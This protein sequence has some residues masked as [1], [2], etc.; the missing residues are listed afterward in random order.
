ML[1]AGAVTLTR[2]STIPAQSLG[3]ASGMTIITGNDGTGPGVNGGTLIFA[4]LTPPVT[5][6]KAAVAINYNPVSYA[7]PTDYAGKFT[8]TEGATL[9]QRMLVFPT[10][11]K[12]ADGSTSVV[13]TG[14]NGLP[15]GVTLV[16]G[17]GATA[18]FDTAGA[19]TNIGITYSGYTLAGPD[20]GKYALAVSCC[21]LPTRSTGTI[22]AAPVVVV[23]PVV[24][25]PVVVP[26]VVVP[27]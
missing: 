17:P 9:T 4:P 2:G 13:L 7:A 19:G 8:L 20:A 15:P 23:P 5:V 27:L 10:A 12:V 16:A 1:I 14:L 18:V 6:T 25:P 11:T 22:T 26:P 21:G 3:L 24:V